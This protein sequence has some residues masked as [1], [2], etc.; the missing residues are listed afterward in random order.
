MQTVRR[1]WHVQFL[2]SLF[3]FFLNPRLSNRSGKEAEHLR[4][5]N[6]RGL[7]RSTM[8]GVPDLTTDGVTSVER[9]SR[10]RGIDR[11]IDCE[12]MSAFTVHAAAVNFPRFVIEI[13]S[14]PATLGPFGTKRFLA[15]DIQRVGVNNVCK[16]IDRSAHASFARYEIRYYVGAIPLKR[17]RFHL[18]KIA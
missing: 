5:A 4:D 12:T 9:K 6:R 3:F 10:S 13:P 15:E 7:R 11:R 8:G 16:S 18:G 2:F 14:E 17:E 1:I